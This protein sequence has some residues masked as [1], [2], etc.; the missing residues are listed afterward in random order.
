MDSNPKDQNNWELLLLSQE[1]SS[2]VSASSNSL[3][4]NTFDSSIQLFKSF[5]W[6]WSSRFYYRLYLVLIK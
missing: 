3:K 4:W 2:E 6:K 5:F 1:L